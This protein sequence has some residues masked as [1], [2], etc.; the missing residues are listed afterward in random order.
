MSVCRRDGSP[1]S[2]PVAPR[3]MSAGTSSV[4]PRGGA[5]APGKSRQSPAP[6]AT[7]AS[8]ARA[9]RGVRVVRSCGMIDC[10]AHSLRRAVELRRF[11]VVEPAVIDRQPAATVLRVN[12]HE[13]VTEEDIIRAI[14]FLSL[15]GG[16]DYRIDSDD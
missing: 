10:R 9:D 1:L 3:S 12:F 5:A 8:A 15:N 4:P 11:G 16:C 7:P 14:V 2:A 6:R 13:A